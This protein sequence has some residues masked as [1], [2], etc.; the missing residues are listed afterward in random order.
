MIQES[1]YVP[2][3]INYKKGTTLSGSVPMSVLVSN[4]ATSTK[5]YST[6]QQVQ[7]DYQSPS[8]PEL[9]AATTYFAN[10]GTELLIFQQGSDV[11]DTDAL[12]SLLSSYSNFIWVTFAQEKTIEQIQTISEVLSSTEQQYDK[13]LALTTNIENA[14]TTLN[15]AG[16]SNVALLYQDTTA[17]G[18]T[19]TPYSAIVISAYF[20]GINLDQPNSLKSIVHTKLSSISASDVNSTQLTNL[21][22]GNWNVIVD[23]AGR[24]TTF[25][26]G[27][28]VNGQPIHSAWGF[29]IFKKNCED[30]IIE[31]LLGKLTYE[32]SSN[33]VIEN[34]I[35]RVCNY[36]VNNGLIGTQ[37]IYNQDTQVESY[38]G[39]QYTTIEKGQTLVN[40]YYIYSIP[41]S[42]ATPQDIESGTIPPI[43][44][45][46]VINDVI[47]IVT[48]NGEVSK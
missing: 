43:Y 3:S 16:I 20:S 39:V 1:Y 26:G 35:G 10:G 37:R 6:L 28:M 12:N 32:N 29:N 17:L 48:I 13:F 41:V 9:L 18:S 34:A 31:L 27:K 19:L 25:D 24:F 21:V 22:S 11:S 14:P 36:F 33:A 42:V 4:T 5:I 30:T 44:I 47:R 2:I 8:A 7:S 46:A 23:L 45:Y 15:D 38:N 40:G